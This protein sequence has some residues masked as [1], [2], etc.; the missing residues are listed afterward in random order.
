MFQQV[1]RATHQAETPELQSCYLFD[2]RLTL[3]HYGGGGAGRNM[4]EHVMNNLAM[5]AAPPP[6][7]YELSVMPNQPMSLI[8]KQRQSMPSEQ[9]VEQ[10]IQATVRL[11]QTETPTYI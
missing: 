8:S 4:N 5:V 2:G 10:R 11:P 9:N 1:D 3:R 7:S 6:P